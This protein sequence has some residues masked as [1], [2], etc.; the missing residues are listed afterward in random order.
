[1]YAIL[2]RRVSLM[3][4]KE[5]KKRTEQLTLKEK[6]STLMPHEITELALIREIKGK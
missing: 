3:S 2:K 6:H 1:M 5:R 4:F